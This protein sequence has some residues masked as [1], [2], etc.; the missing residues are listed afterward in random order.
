MQEE[1]E[2][3]YREMDVKA[4]A[5][6]LPKV[7]WSLV[8]MAMVSFVAAAWA[9][10]TPSWA[11][12]ELLSMLPWF[13][14]AGGLLGFL[15]TVLARAPW[16]A[17]VAEPVL[18][19]VMLVGGLATL[20]FPSLMSSFAGAFGIVSIL[21][22][23]YVLFAALEMYAKGV[24]VW[25]VELALAVVVWVLAFMG[26]VGA[27]GLDGQVMLA[28]LAFFV[29]AWGFVYGAVVLT[30]VDPHAVPPMPAEPELAD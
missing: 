14:I 19:V 9:F 15:G 17:S 2:P 21:L 5:A 27:L 8:F 23:F 6:G 26:L 11:A 12:G 29:A 24:G 3:E 30:G 22:A 10:V 28:S 16:T 25:Y 7:K 20:N 4:L 13:C 1:F 18:C